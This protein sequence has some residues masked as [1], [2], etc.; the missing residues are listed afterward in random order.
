MAQSR[1]NLRKLVLAMHAYAEKNNGTLPPPAIYNK[2]GKALLSWRVAL[3][4]YLDHNNLYKLFHLDEPWDSEHNKQL[5][6]TVV[7]VYAPVGKQD[8]PRS[9]T[10]YQVF[11]SAAGAAKGESGSAP[12]SGAGAGTADAAP[13]FTGVKAAFVKGQQMHF[14]AHFVDGTA[15][16]L[17]IVEAGNAVPWTKPEDLHYAADEPLPELGGLFPDVFQAAF[18]SGDVMVLTKKYDEMNLRFAITSNGGEVIDM[19]K[20]LAP[21]R[22]RA[23]PPAGEDAAI[24][25]WWQ[26][27]ENLRHDLDRARENLRLLKAER[28]LQREQSDRTDKKDDPRLERL[29]RENARLQEELDKVRAES[30]A[31]TKEIARRQKPIQRKGQ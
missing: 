17:L 31:L 13:A 8:V 1:L 7:K 9:R 21:R 26:K 30:E 15:N 5:S 3:L 24:E 12:A 27:N 2:K 14:P 28:A 23:Q 22:H 18:A 16:T 20:I 4:P 29:K 19:E 6:E 11:V 10:Y 25:S